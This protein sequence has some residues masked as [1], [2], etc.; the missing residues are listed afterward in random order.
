MKPFTYSRYFSAMPWMKSCVSGT[1]PN[2]I[3]AMAGSIRPIGSW[4]RLLFW[5]V[6]LVETFQR[7]NGAP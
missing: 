7:P 3:L 6:S 5:S 4:I 1:D 2:R